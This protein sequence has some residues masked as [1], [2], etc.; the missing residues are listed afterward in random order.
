MVCNQNSLES[1]TAILVVKDVF[2]DH[3]KGEGMQVPSLPRGQSAPGL[4][5]E[6]SFKRMILERLLAAS[7][8]RTG[9]RVF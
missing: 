7:L 1:I 9:N 8:F 6:I 5:P 3:C 2:N 4:T